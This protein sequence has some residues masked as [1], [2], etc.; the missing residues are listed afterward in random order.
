MKFVTDI[1]SQLSQWCQPHI[2]QIALTL[3]A[4]LLV[5]YGDVI[6]KHI[7][8]MVSPYHFI[9]RTFAFVIMCAF[10]YGALMLFITPFIKDILLLIPYLYR[11]ISIIFS[12]LLLGFLAENRRY[13]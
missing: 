7:K 6:N 4:T 3:L 9:V 5:I 11:G 10:G 1:L 2:S 12:F 13:I 8:R